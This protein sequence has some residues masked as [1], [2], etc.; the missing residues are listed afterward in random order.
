M[1]HGGKDRA[2]RVSAGATMQRHCPL[3][4]ERPA[5]GAPRRDPAV[6]ARARAEIEG[7]GGY[8]PSVGQ[9]D[10]GELRAIAVQC[11]YRRRLDRDRPLPQLCPRR[12]IGFCR[13]I[14][15]ERGR[16]PLRDQHR[17][18]HRQGREVQHTEVLP[19]HLVAMAV[20]AVKHGSS[21]PLGKPRNVRQLVGDA[22]SENEHRRVKRLPA[23][24]GDTKAIRLGRGADRLG[25]HERRP[26]I[27]GDLRPCRG[28]Q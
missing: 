17:L 13:A 14:E 11:L 8:P 24:E 4:R 27:G 25:V 3:T 5:H 21:P 16:S 6:Q 12:R 23:R 22:E 10:R 28:Q 20:W 1:G 15:E 19:T 9:L 2:V 7:V 26:R 18:V